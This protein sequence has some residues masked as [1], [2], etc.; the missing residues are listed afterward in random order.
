MPITP[1]LATQAKEDIS[2]FVDQVLHVIGDI[3]RKPEGD[4]GPLF[5]KEM[6]DPLSEAW[7]EFQKDFDSRVAKE[8]I[9]GVV[10]QSLQD[11]GLY[12]AQAAGKRKLFE[13]RLGIFKKQRTKQALL[14]LLD[15]IDT[16]LGSIID[17]TGLSKALK[18]IKDIL[19]NSIYD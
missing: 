17:A 1:E 16:Y 12:G 8:R 19:R 5:L 18:E 11:H 2:Q 6:M 15:S 3:I 7:D 9:F 13:I 4:E 14:W 10:D